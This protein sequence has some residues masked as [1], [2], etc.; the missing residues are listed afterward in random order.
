[1]CMC[2]TFYLLYNDQV[3]CQNSTVS[4]QNAYFSTTKWK[5]DMSF[6]GQLN[7]LQKINNNFLATD[8]L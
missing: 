8:V 4:P 6:L 3:S 1:M 7:P 2:F 5:C